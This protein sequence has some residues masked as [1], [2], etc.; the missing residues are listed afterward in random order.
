MIHGG[1]LTVDQCWEEIMVGHD[2]RGRVAVDGLLKIIGGVA[3]AR[4]ELFF[5]YHA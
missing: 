2:S 1:R 4:N 5:V 3:G